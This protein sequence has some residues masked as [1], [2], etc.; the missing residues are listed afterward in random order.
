MELWVNELWL[1]GTALLF[2]VVG[3]RFGVKSQIEDTVGTVIDG[4]IDQGFLK[5]EGIGKDAE[6]IPWKEWCDDQTPGEN[7]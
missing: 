4:L 5:V 2:T 3:F 1:L 7:S 6:I